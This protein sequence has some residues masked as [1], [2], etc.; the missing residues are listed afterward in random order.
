MM[1]GLRVSIDEQVVG[2]LWL[3]AKKHFCFQYDKVWLE[4][5]SIPLSLSLPLRTAPYK[6][7]AL[8]RLMELMGEQEQKA[9]RRLT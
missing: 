5:S 6:C 2:R 7:D 3:D 4:Q 1:G 8:S 9:V